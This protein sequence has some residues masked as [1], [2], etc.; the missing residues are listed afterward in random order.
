LLHSLRQILTHGS[1]TVI[2]VAIAFSLP[3]AARYILFEWWPRA[4]AEPNLL[5]AS[6]IA[7]ASALVLLFNL[8][9]IA[10]DGRHVAGT[11]RLA[12]LVHARPARHGWFVR[13]RERALIR[14]LPAARDAF[15][16]TLTGYDLLVDTRSLL[17]GVLESAYEVR[18]ML[19]NPIG[20]GLRRRVESLPPDVTLLTFHQEI[21]AS[22]AGLAELRKRGKRVTLKFYDHEP[23]W[24][25]V[26]LGE[27]VWVQH[28]HAGFSVREQP[29][30]VFALR[31]HNPREG[32]FVPFYTHFLN[33]WNAHHHP[34]YDFDSNELVY[35][36][37]SGNETKRMPLGVPVNGALAPA[38]A[39]DRRA[40]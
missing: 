31:Q 29:E 13:S 20:E 33:Q 9:K 17:R 11:A 6:E 23:F 18:V 8:A 26:V 2:A 37:A 4:E 5:L 40:A 28:C 32:F 16:M 35:R 38:E 15:I 12:A 27:H 3:P 36:D 10:W 1:I 24:K 30:Y 25:V 34:E 7:L 14:R 19:V 39:Q 22:I 21:E